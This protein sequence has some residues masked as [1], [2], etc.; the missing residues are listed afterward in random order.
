MIKKM[1]LMILTFMTVSQ[2]FAALPIESPVLSDDVDLR[3]LH[4]DKEE[5]SRVLSPKN[6]AYYKHKFNQHSTDILKEALYDSVLKVKKDKLDKTACDLGLIRYFYSALRRSGFST[7]QNSVNEYIY[8]LRSYN[9]IDDIFTKLLIDLNQLETNLISSKEAG[10]STRWIRTSSYIIQ[11]ND[12]SKVYNGFEVW[13]DEEDK[14]LLGTWAKFVNS[15]NSKVKNQP[16][17]SEI[18]TLNRYALLKKS[19]SVRTFQKLEVLRESNILERK[20]FLGGYLN[21]TFW[22]K[23]T[24]TPKNARRYE[25]PIEQESRFVSQKAFLF[26]D[27]S[28]REAFY[29]KYNEDQIII[30]SNILKMASIRMGVDPDIES[31]IPVIFQDLT[32]QDEN[33]EY[34]TIR[35]E[36]TMDNATDQY[37]YALRRMRMDIYATNYY[38]AFSHL[39]I[40]YIDLVLAGLETG[41]ITHEEVAIVLQ[42]DDLWNKQE[43]KLWKAIKFTMGIG[44]AAVFYLPPPYNVVGAIGVALINA[45]IINK[46]TGED[47][48]NPNSIFN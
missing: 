43:S 23:N 30:L 6:I 45:G 11:N 46:P 25:I 5:A 39:K 22:A 36:Y 37:E 21:K 38:G 3:L 4:N 19:I 35:D 16:S 40:D 28:R 9:F 10:Y 33:G 14:C 29:H 18:K 1:K 48:D 13:P 47:N 31:S 41:Y 8:T 12:V 27:I 17:S 15:L 34:V 24:M 26:K 2:G 44:G 7:Q 20:I 42:Y 32:Y